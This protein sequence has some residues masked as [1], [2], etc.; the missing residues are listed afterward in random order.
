MKISTKW[1]SILGI[2]FFIWI[3]TSIDAS[4]V[5]ENISKANL[6]I[7]LIAILTVPLNVLLM[8]KKWQL[9]V[10]FFEKKF[11]LKDA[12]KNY[13]IGTAYGTAT[14]GRVGDFVKLFD[15][16]K[17][18]G[19]AKKGCFSIAFFDRLADLAILTFSAFSGLL[20]VQILT[21]P[22][23]LFFMF[24]IAMLLAFLMI[25]SAFLFFFSKR[26]SLF[27]L[28]KILF[29]LPKNLFEKIKV[30]FQ[31]MQSV[32]VNVKIGKNFAAYF[33][34][35]LAAWWLAFLRPY[36]FALSIGLAVDPLVFVL[37][38]PAVTFIE[39]LPISLFGLGTRDAALILF[40]S[41]MGS[42]PEQ[43]VAVSMLVLFCGN[44]PQVVAG[45]Y[46]AWKEKLKIHF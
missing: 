43:M 19:I 18:T 24:E 37:L 7:V 30:F 15:L 31:K 2:I 26:K 16:N 23:E 46:F 36:I 28:Q 4:R 35:S 6:L 10:K 8:G 32:L 39:I 34:V 25:L 40:F 21:K 13:L 14:P 20:L 45:L 38:I 42:T 1:L 11:S 22:N 3:F 41:F 12:T 27:L 33:V 29:F 17:K 5:L 44:L 9:F